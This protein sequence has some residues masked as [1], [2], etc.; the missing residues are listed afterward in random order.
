MARVD[1]S[2][3]EYGAN[4]QTAKLNSLPNFWLINIWYFCL[5]FPLQH[6]FIAYDDENMFTYVYYRDTVSGELY[7][8]GTIGVDS[9]HMKNA[10]PL[11][12]PFHSL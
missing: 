2:E 4:H 7:M 3:I 9:L 11:F 6:V 10:K 5:F 12:K 8:C 1:L